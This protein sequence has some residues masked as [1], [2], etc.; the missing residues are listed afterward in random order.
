MHRRIALFG[1]MMLAAIAH[2]EDV[3][4]KPA[5]PLTGAGPRIVTGPTVQAAARIGTPQPISPPGV[6]PEQIADGPRLP[7]PP[8]V[9]APAPSPVVILPQRPRFPVVPIV[10]TPPELAILP[11]PEF[12]PRPSPYNPAATEQPRPYRPAPPGARLLRPM[13][14]A[15]PSAVPTPPPMPMAVPDP[16]PPRSQAP[17]FAPRPGRK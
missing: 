6:L 3:Q 4:W 9:E 8:A 14:S 16:A 1:T 12:G 15:T 5:Q 2:A 11:G 7:P 13:P 17:Y 10:D